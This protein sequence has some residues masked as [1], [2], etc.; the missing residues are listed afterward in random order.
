MGGRP[1]PSVRGIINREV[2]SPATSRALVERGDVQIAFDSRQGRLGS[3]K[4]PTVYLDAE[5]RTAT[6]CACLPTPI[7]AFF[8]ALAKTS[9]SD[10]LMTR[11]MRW[12]GKISTIDFPRTLIC[13]PQYLD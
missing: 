13:T 6:Q 4:G 9:R 10:F 5:R 11:T 2:P 3:R 12:I 1:L 8:N 7:Q